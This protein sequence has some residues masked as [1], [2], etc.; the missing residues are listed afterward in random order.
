MI[1]ALA[2]GFILCTR[3][4]RKNDTKVVSWVWE[5]IVGA[6]QSKKQVDYVITFN[7]SSNTNAWKNSV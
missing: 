6:M 1:H 2:D 7:T 5:Y 4:F 3:F